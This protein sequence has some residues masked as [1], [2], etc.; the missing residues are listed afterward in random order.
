MQLK[1]GGS[2][3][4]Y[5][6]PFLSDFRAWTIDLRHPGLLFESTRTHRIA[7]QRRKAAHLGR[8]ELF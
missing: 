1:D 5:Q 4:T 7:E 6:T 3:W 2:H 8:L